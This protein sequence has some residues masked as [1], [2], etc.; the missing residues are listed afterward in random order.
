MEVCQSV[1]IR[2]EVGSV[3]GYSES[4]GLGAPSDQAQHFHGWTVTALGTVKLWGL[5][6]FGEGEEFLNLQ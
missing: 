4:W 2:R 5:Q 1:R 3:W 6:K